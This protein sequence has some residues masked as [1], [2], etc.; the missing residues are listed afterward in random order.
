L[1]YHLNNTHVA[2]T[3]NNNQH[4][5]E[6]LNDRQQSDLHQRKVDTIQ[7]PTT[8]SEIVAADPR[9]ASIIGTEAIVSDKAA[10]IPR[11]KIVKNKPAKVPM[12]IVKDKP[13]KAPKFFNGKA[14]EV[15]EQSVRH[16]TAEVSDKVVDDK[17]AEHLVKASVENVRVPCPSCDATFKTKRN[18]REHVK[19]KHEAREESLRF[20]CPSCDATFKAA[21]YLRKHVKSEHVGTTT[22]CEH[23]GESFDDAWQLYSHQRK[24][25]AMWAPTAVAPVVKKIVRNKAAAVTKQNIKDN[26]AD[27]PAEHPVGKAHEVS[28]ENVQGKA[29]KVLNRTGR[30]RKCP[31]CCIIMPSPVYKHHFKT[32]HPGAPFQRAICLYP[33][34]KCYTLCK[35]QDKLDYHLT[36]ELGEVRK[37]ACDE[38]GEKFAYSAGK[39]SRIW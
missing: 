12:K 38:C 7:E 29:A 36:K 31:V 28:A 33:C 18:L 8:V 21:R 19:R 3:F 35:S 24:V 5:G 15:S 2:T 13:A 10:G 20:P 25:H 37:Y 27:V 14:A 1:M 26:A 11:K 4:C 17:M 22:I 6:S 16:D 23:C 32:A 34:T 30:P 9:G 39:N